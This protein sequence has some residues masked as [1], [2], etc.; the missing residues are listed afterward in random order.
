MPQMVF[1]VLSVQRILP[2]RVQHGQLLPGHAGNEG[3]VAPPGVQGQQLA[4]GIVKLERG[5]GA[6]RPG[7]VPQVP[8]K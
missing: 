2:G 8:V 4:V 6:L 1:F 7:D 3:Q 5:V